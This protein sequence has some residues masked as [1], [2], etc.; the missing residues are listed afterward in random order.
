MTERQPVRQA[1]DWLVIG[2]LLVV[3]LAPL[4]PVFTLRALSL[5]VMT[6]LGLATLLA[7][8]GWRWRLGAAVLAAG[9]VVAYLVGG[10]LLVW[11]GGGTPSQPLRAVGFLA[12]N[13]T[14]VWKRV[15]TVEI[16][17]GSTG[18]FIL[19]PYLMA[20]V[21]GLVA[22]SLVWRL[23]GRQAGW[24]AM[25]PVA[26]LA[27]SLIMGSGRAVVPLP[28][29]LAAAGLGLIWLSW[30]TGQFEARR[31]LAVAVCLAV[32]GGA[33][34][35]A[36]WLVAQQPRLVVR[37]HLEPPFNPTDHPSPLAAYRHY[38]KDLAKT[39]LLRTSA[40][41]KA[42]GIRLAVMDRYD[43]VVWNVATGSGRFERLAEG[44]SLNGAGGQVT[45]QLTVTG[46][47][48]VWLYSVGQPNAVGFS[49]RQRH[50]LREA[51][52]INRAAGAL[53]LIGGV[54]AGASYTITA[55]V[56]ER[57]SDSLIRQAQAMKIDLPPLQAVPDAVRL[58]AAELTVGA[59]TP[60]AKALA[61]EQALTQQG[62]FS[63]G[64]IGQTS[65]ALASLAG[66]GAARIEQFLTSPVMVGD[67][68]QY[69]SAMALMARELG[70]PARV[71][72]GFAPADRAAEDNQAG[73]SDPQQVFYGADMT[74]WVEIGLAG[75]GWVPF[76]PTPERHNTPGVAKPEP[77]PQPRP[78]VV[79]PPP[80]AAR[81]YEPAEAPSE[82]RLVPQGQVAEHPSS[83]WLGTWLRLGGVGLAG[84]LSL[85]AGPGL[86]ILVK[87]RRRHNRATQGPPGLQMVAGWQEVLDRMTDLRLALPA[88]A[89]RPEQAAALTHRE[90]GRLAARLAD[91][92]DQ[93]A[94]G[95]QAMAPK[96][97]AAYWCGVG[98]LLAMLDQAAS[99][100]QRWR[101][102]TS[103]RSLRRCRLDQ[104]VSGPRAWAIMPDQGWTA[105]LS[106]AKVAVLH[107]DGSHPSG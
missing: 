15:L 6:G 2:L 52:R 74:A 89:T 11:L 40:L 53:V 33:G 21:G 96:Q 32:A 94:F 86:A 8:A 16:P 80:K 35:G 26:V 29:G 95:C 64:Q 31:W 5:P 4:V 9:G 93:A 75:F 101:A 49:G 73:P 41:P 17:V 99:R 105:A 79:Q 12:A 37:Q 92:T 42:Q 48:T 85:V 19:A 100:R 44:S 25:V 82:D 50:Q 81:P 28:A 30:R 51:V 39:E 72:M 13:T 90:A 14:T 76:Y 104:P 70:L 46:P 88:M 38:V 45:V 65:P 87:A 102:R 59:T 97:A 47:H 1:I 54:P 103:W 10:Y 58:T 55:R 71:V 84:I 24:A 98:R 63:H 56:A 18:G 60:G 69:A 83:G 22:W 34:G 77:E 23:A 91:L 107:H 106:R 61:L 67:A 7:L 20:L 68:E 78:Q 57:P 36:H 3:A 66:H 62:Y 43:G 27:T